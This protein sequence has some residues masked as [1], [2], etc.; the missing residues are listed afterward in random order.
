MTAS[1]FV[2]EKMNRPAPEEIFEETPSWKKLSKPNEKAA[3]AG[4]ILPNKE[5]S[6]K[7]LK[8]PTH[9]SL[10]KRGNLSPVAWP[11]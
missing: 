10:K 1:D 11:S 7:K 2:K 9:I 4:A 5:G 3:K 8:V 6:F